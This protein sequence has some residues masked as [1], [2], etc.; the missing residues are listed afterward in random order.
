M[1]QLSILF[2][3]CACFSF[4]LF[5]FVVHFQNPNFFIFLLSLPLVIAFA[6]CTIHNEQ[7][8]QQKLWDGKAHRENFQLFRFDGSESGGKIS[9]SSWY[10]TVYSESCTEVYLDDV[11]AEECE[12]MREKQNDEGRN[13]LATMRAMHVSMIYL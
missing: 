2:S 9:F 1:F 3:F 5:S 10:K 6:S 4:T 11:A 12:R 8:Q 7:Q 13:R